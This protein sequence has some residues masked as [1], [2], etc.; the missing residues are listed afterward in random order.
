[1]GIAEKTVLWYT[2]D[3]GALKV[4]STAGL[5]GRKGSLLEGGIRVPAIIEWPGTIT[6]HRIIN[7][8]CG[9]VDIYP[10]V[11]E[12]AGVSPKTNQPILDGQSLVPVIQSEAFQRRSPLGFWVYDKRGRPMK[13][14]DLL[15]EMREN[16][17]PALEVEP[18]PSVI[19]GTVR[20]ENPQGP[21]AWLDGDWKLHRVPVEKEQG[22]FIYRLYN[23]KSDPKEKTDL[24]AQESGRAGRMQKEL[25]H[26]QT[27]VI[28]SLNG[29]DYRK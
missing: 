15:K 24:L 6:R 20:T 27:S 9:T 7:E 1:M 11:L 14:T 5:S 21:A 17:K 28:N 26:W 10:T 12:L 2:S 19:A 25:A 13:S 23:L 3:N 22:K 29:K 16:P 18:D 8:T 4:G